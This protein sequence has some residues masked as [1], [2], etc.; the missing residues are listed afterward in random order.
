MNLLLTGFEPFGGSTINPSE[1]VVRALARE[2]LDG[3]ALHT[4]IL[5]VDRARGPATVIE[6]ARRFQPD[7]I[8]CLGEASRRLA[9]SIERV[10]INLMDYRIADNSGQQVVDEPIA[11]DGPAAYFVTLP[12][13]AMLEAA[14]A[15]GAPAELSLSAGA[16][17]CNQVTY[18]ILHHLA[19][20]QLAIP[21]GFIHLPALPEQAVKHYPLIP[22]MAVETM[23]RGVTAAI[24][25]IEAH[26]PAARLQPALI[27]E[28][29][30][31][32]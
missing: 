25:A 18:A 1:Q 13:R 29:A 12:T 26:V 6:A 23:V 32:R 11:P 17:L 19:Q 22:S 16:F 28:H 2:G 15:A 27:E 24:R 10:A 30:Y 7:A 4:A 31:A 20:N 5:P 9:I 3:I 8:L 14:R 21:A